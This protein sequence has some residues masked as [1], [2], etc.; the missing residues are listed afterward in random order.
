MK[1]KE[2]FI[3]VSS[4][5]VTGSLIVGTSIDLNEKKVIHCDN[6]DINYID[7]LRNCIA[8]NKNFN[9]YIKEQLYYYLLRYVELEN[10]HDYEIINYAN[11]CLTCSS[12]NQ[13][14]AFK[15]VFDLK[16]NIDVI[17]MMEYLDNSNSL[18]YY[19]VKKI[20]K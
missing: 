4:I 15:Y 12:N 5:L 1:K 14:D 8:T 7:Y 2:I 9:K 18:E 11:K 6:E 16:T 13:I 3:Y 10:L 19:G 17:D 20:K